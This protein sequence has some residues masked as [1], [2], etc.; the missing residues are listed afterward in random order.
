MIDT[1]EKKIHNVECSVCGAIGPWGKKTPIIKTEKT[2]KGYRIK[3][4]DSVV[5]CDKCLEI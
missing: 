2:E 1:P 5:F 4:G 3:L